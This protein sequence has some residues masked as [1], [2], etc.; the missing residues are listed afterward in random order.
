MHVLKRLLVT[1]LLCGLAA[2]ITASLLVICPFAV[3]EF[4]GPETGGRS[5]TLIV[6]L[7]AVGASP[8]ILTLCF[9][10][11]T[12]LVLGLHFFGAEKLIKRIDH[13]YL[14][15]LLGF[16]IG[17]AYWT[18]IDLLVPLYPANRDQSAIEVAAYLSAGIT[19]TV[20]TLRLNQQKKS[21]NKT[22]HHNPLPAE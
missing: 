3:N 6:L 10:Y 8:L 11:S 18:L 14:V 15:G 1:S 4:F 21:E 17:I 2:T 20:A 19:A 13:V 7:T 22:S 5:T 16:F 9:V 12:P